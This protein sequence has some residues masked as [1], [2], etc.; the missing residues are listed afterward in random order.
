M[1][2]WEIS[3]N[4]KEVAELLGVTTRAAQIRAAREGWRYSEQ[5]GRRLYPL[6]SLPADVQAASFQSNFS[7]S[8][9]ESDSLRHPDPESLER[10]SE[11][12][13]EGILRWLRILHEF[14]Q[15][16]SSQNQKKTK[17]KTRKAFCQSYRARH[18]NEAPFSPGTLKE[19]LR[20]FR[21]DGYEGLEVRYGSA[22]KKLA[23]WPDEAKAFLKQQ[24][25]HPNRPPM[26]FCIDQ[27][28]IEG[29]R[30]GWRLPSPATMRRFL[31]SIDSEVC[32]FHRLGEKYWRQHY[33]P[34]VLR[35]Y[36]QLRPNEVWVADHRQFNVAVRFSSG[37]T[38]FPWVS[39]FLDM[40]TRI[41]V[42]WEICETP[43]SDSIRLALKKAIEKYGCA[44]HV[45]LDNG[46]DYASRLLSGKSKRIRTHLDEKEF[47]GIFLQLKIEPHFCIPGNPQSK[48]V[49]R[50]FWTQETSF[51]VAFLTYRG[52]GI[53]TRPEGVDRRIKSGKHTPEREEFLSYVENW[54]TSYNERPHRGHGM[55]GRSPM[56]VWNEYFKTHEQR[57]VSPASLRLL[58]MKGEKVKVGRFGIRAF[59]SYY[60]DD[61]VME[62]ITQWV[63][64]RY[65][66]EDLTRIHVYT[67]KDEYISSPQQIRRTHWQ[68]EAAYAEVK[69]LEKRKR[70][71][72]RA[73]REAAERIYKTEYG[74]QPR[75]I[76]DSV[77]PAKVI[78]VVRTPFDGLE[79]RISGN[80][81]K[82]V[83]V[84]TGCLEEYR[85]LLQTG[86][87][88]NSEDQGQPRL[89]L[90]FG[91]DKSR[92]TLNSPY[93]MDWFSR[94]REVEE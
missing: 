77:E 70:Q 33:L 75:E 40:K 54:I 25:L 84:G 80:D 46:V 91:K 76:K 93:S 55:N 37:K 53:S 16:S 24:F 13:R 7:H 17:E 23:A 74:Y 87:S 57:K 22:V 52:N 81:E 43:S 83:A 1:S 5:N 94:D 42:G 89:S 92:K 86:N 61:L 3:L 34:S 90:V 62:R 41:L 45:I 47:T 39:A 19:K 73:E 82:K 67:L 10:L 11:K 28:K 56:Q 38:L 69:K 48:S 20:R 79:D 88:T 30:K 32:D 66:P 49:E 85:A 50:L 65:D 78:R 26:S 2:D 51:D 14:D 68:D 36:E 35:D 44:E 64:Y 29:K 27:L 8:I 12:K 9:C 6:T 4:S 18:P 72:I 63:I 21:R 71:A 31:N 15:Y 59:G 58:M 60:R